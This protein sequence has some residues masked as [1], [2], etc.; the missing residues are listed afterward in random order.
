MCDSHGAADSRADQPQD[1]HLQNVEI[2]SRRNGRDDSPGLYRPR[3]SNYPPEGTGHDIAST[4]GNYVAD[5]VP[6]L[7]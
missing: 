2:V 3:E 5:L 7:E 1:S 4:R 6:I